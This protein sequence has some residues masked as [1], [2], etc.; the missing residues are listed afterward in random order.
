MKR[1]WFYDCVKLIMTA[2]AS[3]LIILPV[4]VFREGGNH[5]D[6]RWLF[7]NGALVSLLPFF[8]LV[9]IES[10]R[11]VRRF[12]GFFADRSFDGLLARMFLLQLTIFVTNVLNAAWPALNTAGLQFGMLVGLL[13][14]VPFGTL[15]QP[16][17]KDRKYWIK[18][19]SIF[20]PASGIIIGLVVF[21]L[22]EH[23]YSAA[24]KNG[25]AS[26]V[27]Y[28]GGLWLGLILG[29]RIGQ[30]ILALQPVFQLLRRLGRILIAFAVGYLAIILLFSTFYAAV[31]RV[32]GAEA[33][34]GIP[35]DPRLQV[36]FYFSL[37]TATTIGYGDII[38]HSES[39]R[40][41]VGLESLS[42][43]AWTLVVFAALSVQFADEAKNKKINEESQSEPHSP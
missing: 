28:A 2:A 25:I 16:G 40:I 12:H 42:S 7:R 27:Y 6:L 17:I 43:L 9:C 1:N 14:P 23:S 10:F 38:P 33:L 26:S 13:T 32:Q 34:S 8:L 22:S 36:F 35:V 41:L 20:G 29:N 24:L 3:V 4:Y 37:V 30:W 31:W 5:A 19:A 18:L 11:N 15:D 39:A 21:L